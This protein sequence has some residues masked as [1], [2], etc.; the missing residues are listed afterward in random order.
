MSDSQV[1]ASTW[2][3]IYVAI[4]SVVYFAPNAETQ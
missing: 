1:H 3:L 4:L 2:C